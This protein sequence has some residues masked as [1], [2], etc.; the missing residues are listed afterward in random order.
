MEFVVGWLSALG[1]DRS[2][3]SGALM[4]RSGPSA[5]ILELKFLPVRSEGSQSVLPSLGDLA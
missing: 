4:S 2:E 5:V 1:A 3:D